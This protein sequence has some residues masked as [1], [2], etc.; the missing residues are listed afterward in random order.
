MDSVNLRVLVDRARRGFYKLKRYSDLQGMANKL[1]FK[2]LRAQY[3]CQIWHNAAHEIGAGIEPWRNGFSR[4]SRGN[5]ATFVRD[6]HVMLDDH[7]TLEIM[8]N[9]SL[10]YDIMRERGD[11]VPEYTRFT[12]QT[13]ENAVT[14]LARKPRPIVIKPESG[15]GGGRGVTTGITTVGQLWKAVRLA[16][17]FD[18]HLIAEEQINGSSYRLLYLNGQFIDAIRRDPPVVVGDGTSTIR[19]LIQVENQRRLSSSSTLALSPLLVDRD[20][21]NWLS[22]QGVS[23][24]TRPELGQITQ[25]KKAVNENAAAQNH[26]VRDH[27]HAST[28][29]F[30]SQLVQDL[31]VDFAGIDIL[32]QDIS[33]P[34]SVENGLVS[35]INTT[36]GIH[37]HYLVH[38]TDQSAPVAEI[39][40][41]HILATGQGAHTIRKNSF[42][43]GAAPLPN[44]KSAGV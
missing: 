6:G 7:L 39:V 31:S 21:V 11:P 1:K 37:H 36:P 16:L 4:I 35:E 15:T 19:R 24:K 3:N 25:V 32:C 9:K 42:I 27:V 29:S 34:L 13:V 22:S 10:V 5:M 26:V 38:E 8:G 23:L 44:R 17:C 14:L 41:E 30:A 40:L 28:I 12:A 43:Q 18:T 33:Q 2:R 20:C